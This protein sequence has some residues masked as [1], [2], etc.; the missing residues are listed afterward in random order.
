MLIGKIEIEAPRML[1]DADTYGPLGSIK[2]RARFEEIERRPD[3]RRAR[4]GPGGLVIAAP[5]PVSEM[6]A[7]NGPSFSMAVRY[8]IG[9]CD[10]GGSVKQLSQRIISLS[11]DRELRRPV[12]S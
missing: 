5:Q 8:E 10:P 3:Y 11:I 7:A 1:S 6:F 12:S 9:E 2:L 4:S